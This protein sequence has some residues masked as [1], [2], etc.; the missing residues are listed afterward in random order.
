MKPIRNLRSELERNILRAWEGLREVLS[1]GSGALTQFVRTARQQKIAGPHEAFPEWALLAAESWE[2]AQ[3]IIVRIE[4]PG[5]SKKDMQISIDR[6]VLRIRG[7]RRAAADHP[8]GR[9]T[10]MERAFGRFERTLPLPHDIDAS[11]AEVSTLAKLKCPLPRVRSLSIWIAVSL[12]HLN[13]VSSTWATSGDDATAAPGAFLR[14]PS[15]ITA[16]ACRGSRSP[17]QVTV[18]FARMPTFGR[19]RMDQLWRFYSLMKRPLANGRGPWK[20]GFAGPR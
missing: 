14:S 12:P 19:R 4:I 7:E 16:G 17:L 9:Y 11:K 8:T 20:P 18:I 6:G 1:R 2:T 3:S 10:L 13:H 15:G 5:M